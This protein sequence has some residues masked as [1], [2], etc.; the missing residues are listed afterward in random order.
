MVIDWHLVVEF[1]L[2]RPWLAPVGSRQ[3]WCVI[4]AAIVFGAL[5]VDPVPPGAWE[6]C[7]PDRLHKRHGQSERAQSAA[8]T[9]PI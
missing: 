6:G 5:R 4:S 1:L 7:R 9:V 8:R 3:G 2:R